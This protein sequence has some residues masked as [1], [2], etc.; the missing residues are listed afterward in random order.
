MRSDRHAGRLAPYCSATGFT[1]VV[2]R[3][4]HYPALPILRR[5]S[6]EAFFHRDK[7]GGG[8]KKSTRPPLGLPQWFNG[9]LHYP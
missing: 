7:L 8:Q 6:A 4:L 2:Q 3:P 1:P 5:R 9:L